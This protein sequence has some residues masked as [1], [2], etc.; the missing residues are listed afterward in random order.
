MAPKRNVQQSWNHIA[1]L[2]ETE[3]IA[4]INS[5][6]LCAVSS[7]AMHISHEAYTDLSPPELISD[8]FYRPERTQI[9]VTVGVVQ[10]SHSAFGDS[11]HPTENTAVHSNTL[12]IFK[13]RTFKRPEIEWR[14]AA[15]SD[16][17]AGFLSEEGT[18]A[19][20]L[21]IV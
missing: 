13:R 7:S 1:E 14:V 3:R 4:A 16:E 20:G 21:M 19:N 6:A 10:S 11:L 17:I 15:L 5:T 8:E 9:H 12:P 18:K 2:T